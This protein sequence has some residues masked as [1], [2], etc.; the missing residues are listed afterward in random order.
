MAGLEA[1]VRLASQQTEQGM[2]ALCDLSLD[3]C[4]GLSGAI[5]AHP[6]SAPAPADHPVVVCSHAASDGRWML[7]VEGADGNGRAYV[8]QVV[9]ARDGDRVVPVREPAY[10]LGIGYS[11]RKVVGSTSWSTAYHPSASV[12]REHTERV[13]ARARAACF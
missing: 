7:V 10:W 12:N 11:S 2:D 5:R 1:M 3:G 8:S 6:E 9:L 13:L 4:G